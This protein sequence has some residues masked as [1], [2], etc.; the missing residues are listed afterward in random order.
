MAHDVEILLVGPPKPTIVDGLAAFTVHRL[1]EARDRNALLC[2]AGPRVRAIASSVTGETIDGALMAKL[3]KLEIVS[4]FGVGYDH[5]DV[6]WAVAHG[7]M[8]TNTPNVLTEEV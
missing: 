1:A 4:T 2:E 8:V 3:P 5:V 7:V 6:A